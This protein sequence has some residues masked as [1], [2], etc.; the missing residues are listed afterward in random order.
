MKA[1]ELMTADPACCTPDDTV[2]S[3]ARSMMDRDCGCLPVVDDMGARHVV[4]VVTDR[5][6]AT[7]ALAQGRGPDTRIREVMS[8]QPACCSPDSE[9]GEVE[10]I[11]A[12]HRVRRVP[13]V[14]GQDCCVG[15]IA[16]ADL[17]CAEREAD[18]HAVRRTV[19]A[20]SQPGGRSRSRSGT[21]ERPDVM[22]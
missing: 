16:Q 22:R 10:R 6:L 11:M 19:E 14:D 4:G 3:A 9:L 20:I 17:A 13:V 21:S 15:M 1:R 2:Q 12:E 8:A 18:D 7:R 5:D